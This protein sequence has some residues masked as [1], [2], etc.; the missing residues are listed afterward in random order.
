MRA[1]ILAAGLGERV[2]PLSALRPKPALPV[3]GMPVIGFGLRLLERHGV[4]E[5]VINRHYLA[6]VLTERTEAVRPSGMELSWSDEPGPLGTGGGL[7]R[8]AEFLA[9]SEQC[10]VLAGDMLLDA[11]LTKLADAH[12]ARGAAVTFLLKEDR[13]GS[14]FGTI[15]VDSAGRVR[16]IGRHFDL[17]GEVSA[18]V[19]VHATVISG[20]TLASLPAQEPSNHLTD[21]I[22]PRLAEGADDVH[23]VVLSE[24][25]C[26]WEPVGTVAEYLAANLDCPRLSYLDPADAADLTG[27]RVDAGLVL[28]AGAT[29]GAGARLERAVVWDGEHVPD[30]FSGSHGVFAGGRFHAV[31]VS[32]SAA[33]DASSGNGAVE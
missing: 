6:S 13:R 24:N 30:G 32:G 15:G 5:V 1:M 27:T 3:R 21:W 16:R 31:D 9:A 4:D 23:G 11:D 28:G 22:V 12:R 20:E 10:I 14:L 8:A 25:E 26:T 17:G 29:L 2:R 19:Y 33:D 18:G 7:R